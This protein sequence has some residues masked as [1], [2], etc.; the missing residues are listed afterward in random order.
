MDK[1]FIIFSLLGLTSC[2]TCYEEVWCVE[3]YPMEWSDTIIHQKDH[4]HF[5]DQN[6]QWT[7]VDIDADTTYLEVKD[8]LYIEKLD[9]VY[10]TKDKKR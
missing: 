7:C 8:T 10:Y 4:W 2:R 3:K 6:N 1:L 9:C 5:K